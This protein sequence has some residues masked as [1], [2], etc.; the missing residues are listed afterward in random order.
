[1]RFIVEVTF[2]MGIFIC[3]AIAI[4]RYIDLFGVE[5]IP[6]YLLVVALTPYF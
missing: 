4:G 6:N 3:M 2:Y 1:M 5:F